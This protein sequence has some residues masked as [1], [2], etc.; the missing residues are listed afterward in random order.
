MY[1]L[2]KV[3]NIYSLFVALC[4]APLVV[5]D[6]WLLIVLLSQEIRSRGLRVKGMPIRS[7]GSRIH[8]LQL[9]AL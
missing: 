1:G 9:A 2:Q 7:S 5:G 8:F 3:S 4:R 6:L